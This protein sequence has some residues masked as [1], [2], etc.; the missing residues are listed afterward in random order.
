MI[1]QHLLVISF[2]CGRFL[3]ENWSRHVVKQKS[4]C[5]GYFRISRI[6]WWF[7]EP[8]V[9]PINRLTDCPRYK[10]GRLVTKFHTFWNQISSPTLSK[11]SVAHAECSEEPLCSTARTVRTLCTCNL[12]LF[13]K[14]QRGIDNSQLR[15]RVDFCGQ[16]TN[17]ADNTHD[18]RI[19]SKFSPYV[20]QRPHPVCRKTLPVSINFFCNSRMDG[21]PYCDLRYFSWTLCWAWSSDLMSVNHA[22]QWA[23]PPGSFHISRFPVSK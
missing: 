5:H 13:C 11:T 18:S 14:L 12:K 3:E 21:L 2:V 9:G 17:S 15:L 10:E 6:I 19:R 20:L 1:L 22:T 7:S 23:S 8:W 4:A 16:H